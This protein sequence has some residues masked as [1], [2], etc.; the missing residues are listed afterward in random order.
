[1][2]DQGWQTVKSKADK[3]KSRPKST[4]PSGSQTDLAKLAFAEVDKWQKP[5][6]SKVEAWLSSADGASTG[7]FTSLKPEPSPPPSPKTAEQEAEPARRNKPKKPKVKKPSVAQV[8][9]DLDVS[10]LRAFLEETVRKYKG[11][12]AAQLQTVADHFLKAFRE[13][14]LP[15]NRTVLEQPLDKVLLST[16]CVRVSRLVPVDTNLPLGTSK[17]MRGTHL[18]IIYVSR[19]WMC[20]ARTC[21]SRQ[22]LW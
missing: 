19:P 6:T 11:D 2:T 17:D 20:H 15:F 4:T 13:C 7:A 8:A 9:T 5:E 18:R 14:D 10:E 12:E 1:M 22:P 16:F 3:A 21:Q